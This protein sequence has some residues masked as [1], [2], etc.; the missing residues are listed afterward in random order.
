M[1]GIQR[2]AVHVDYKQTS[3]ADVV[4]S[5]TQIYAINLIKGV[6]RYFL[7]EVRLVA[8][9]YRVLLD[10]RDLQRECQCTCAQESPACETL[11]Y[12]QNST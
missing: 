12:V 9:A 8:V 2:V 1:F 5:V 4:Y 3:D 7:A 11:N 6:E 10:A